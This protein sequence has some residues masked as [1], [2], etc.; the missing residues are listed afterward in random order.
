MS[1][2]IHKYTSCFFLSTN[3]YFINNFAIKLENFYNFN[4]LILIAEKK[5]V[6]QEFPTALINRLEKHFVVTST[7]LTEE[8]LSIEQKLNEWVQK[9]CTEGFNKKYLYYSVQM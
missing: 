1:R 8:Q 3:P 5:R 2:S 4:R 7:I 9:F 6:Y